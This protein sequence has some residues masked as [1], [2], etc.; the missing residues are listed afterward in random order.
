MPGTRTYKQKRAVSVGPRRN[1][2]TRVIRPLFGRSRVSPAT[3]TREQKSIGDATY[4]SRKQRTIALVAGSA[5][6]RAPLRY[7]PGF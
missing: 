1:N 6:V 5:D 3:Y 7:N 4:T 2:R